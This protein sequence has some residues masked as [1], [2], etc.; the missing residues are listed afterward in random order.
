MKKLITPAGLFGPH[1]VIEVL[2]DRYRCDGAE[3]PF[4]VVGRGEVL[5]ALPDDFPASS[6][7][8]AP[9]RMPRSVTMRQ[10]RLALLGA[11]LL[12]QVDAALAAIPDA[13]H[14]RAAQIEWEYAQTI[15]RDS[16]WVS[17]LS[18]ALD[19]TAE[20]LD[21]LFIQAAAL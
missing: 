6:M 5:D 4:S 7:P 8:P 9:T 19:L 1:E 10:G 21:Q 16:A 20:Q 3:L 15:D 14:R 18:E 17:N 13:T 2:D 12:D 11:G